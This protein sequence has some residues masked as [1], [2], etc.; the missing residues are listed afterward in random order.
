MLWPGHSELTH[1]ALS[2][3]QHPGCAKHVWFLCSTLFLGSEMCPFAQATGVMCQAEQTAQLLY[4][5]NCREANGVFKYS[6]HLSIF[7]FFSPT[8]TFHLPYYWTIMRKIPDITVGWIVELLIFDSFLT[9][10]EIHFIWFNLIPLYL[11]RFQ[12]IVQK[13]VILKYGWNTIVTSK[14]TALA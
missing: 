9:N 14:H 4:H 13:I 11:G 7:V 2:R 6:N 8:Y 5:E 1:I 12:Y 3:W 10:K